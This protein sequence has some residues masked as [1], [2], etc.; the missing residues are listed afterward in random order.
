MFVESADGWDPAKGASEKIARMIAAR[1]FV[2]RRSDAGIECRV[3]R[4]RREVAMP[5]RVKRAYATAERDY[6]LEFDGREIAKTMTAA[7]RW[8]WMRQMCGGHVDGELVW[9]GKIKELL[10]LLRGELARDPVVVWFAYNPE[11]DAAHAALERARITSYRIYGL[12]PRPRR[13]AWVES[14]RRGEARV[15]LAQ[16]AALDRGVD[17]SLADTA[18]YYSTRASGEMRAQTEERIIHPAKDRSLLLI[19]LVVPRTVDED[20]VE[21][22]GV[23]K[24]RS[25]SALR[26]AVDLRVH[27][28]RVLAA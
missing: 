7:A 23:K 20:V 6:V 18:I 14:W 4:Q 24:W 5:P 28:R 1:A 3:N 26:R 19:D 8:T 22:L 11:I 16:M 13:D 2:L 21:L 10:R 27:A 12:D 9:P 25:E 15:L 17:L